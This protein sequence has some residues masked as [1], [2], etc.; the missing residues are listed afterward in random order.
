M[1]EATFDVNARVYFCPIC[2]KTFTVTEAQ[3]AKAEEKYREAVKL[4]E[5]IWKGK[6]IKFTPSFELNGHKAWTYRYDQ[7]YQE[8]I[9]NYRRNKYESTCCKS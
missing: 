6:G 8:E 1:S 9:A 3:Y 5:K 4:S 7:N 2:G